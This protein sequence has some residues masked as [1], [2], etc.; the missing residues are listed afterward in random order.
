MNGNSAAAVV[1]NLRIDGIDLFTNRKDIQARTTEIL[2]KI[3]E[4]QADIVLTPENAMG[5]ASYQEMMA[6]NRLLQLLDLSTTQPDQTI[7]LGAELHD[8]KGFDNAILVIRGGA[9]LGQYN[10]RSGVPL[11][12]W[13]PFQGGTESMR[14]Y[15]LTD[16]ILDVDGVHML[17]LVCY[18][19]YLMYSAVYAITDKKNINVILAPANA[20][21]AGSTGLDKLQQLYARAWGRILGV[22]VV[23][24]VAY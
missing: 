24:A 20:W 1:N 19:Q 6:S 21:W 8:E 18:E 22:P 4:S 3:S 2:E 15:W 14:Q 23:G 16:P 13:K 12:M 17:P 10:A 7:L 5:V 11:S 9:I